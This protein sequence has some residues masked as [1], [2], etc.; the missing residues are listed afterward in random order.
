MFVLLLLV[1][2]WMYFASSSSTPLPSRK[3]VVGV[4]PIATKSPRTSR[5]DSSLV[6]VSLSNTPVMTSSPRTSKTTLFQSTSAFGEL[7]IRFCIAFD[8]R[9]SSRLWMMYTLEPN[10][11][12]KL[13]SS[14]ALSPPP[15]TA[16]GWSRNAGKAPSHT[17]QA[18]TP[19]PLLARRISLSRPIQLAVAPVATITDFARIVSPFDVS[20]LNGEE[21]KSHETMSS[22]RARVPNRSACF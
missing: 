7:K 19:P 15:T 11:V 2:S 4:C 10:L 21:E 18:L 22:P 6:I 3:L 14:R 8:A 16:S 5:V 13:A 17:A 1:L 9:N 20:S 12:K